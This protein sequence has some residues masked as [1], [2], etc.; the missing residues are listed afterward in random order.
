MTDKDCPK[1]HGTGSYMYDENHGKPCELCC[2]HDEGYWQLKEHYGDNN[3]KW[4]CKR[5][6]GH[7]VDK[8]PVD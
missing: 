5:G 2:P 6:C 1:C 8:T 3:D 7:I 4:A